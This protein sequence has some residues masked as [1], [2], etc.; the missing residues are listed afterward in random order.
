MK[1]DAGDEVIAIAKVAEEENTEEND[2]AATGTSVTGQAKL[3]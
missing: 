2:S 1:L 3:F